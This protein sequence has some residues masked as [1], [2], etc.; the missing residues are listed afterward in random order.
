MRLR[1]TL[2]GF[3]LCSLGIF[4][5][6][7][8]GI[9]TLGYVGVNGLIEQIA[10]IQFH[11]ILV[12][13]L[14]EFLG[15][16][17]ILVDLLILKKNVRDV[18]Y[19][20]PTKH[21]Q[22]T[23]VLTAYNDE[24]SIYDI[25]VEFLDHPKVKRV[26]VVSNN[27]SD[28]TLERARKAGAIAVNEPRQGYGSCVYR[29][30]SEGVKYDDTNYTLLCEGDNT[31]RAYD[32]DKFL[33]YIPHADIVNGSRIVEQLRGKDTQL[34]NFM[35]FGNFFV[36]KLLEMKNI[37]NGTLT[38]VG[39]TYKLCKNDVLKKLL[40]KLTLDINLEYNPYF[41]D[42][43]MKY[44]LRVVECPVTFHPRVGESKGGNIND[45]VALKLGLRMIIGIIISWKI[46]ERK[47]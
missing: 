9:F 47:G 14:L 28:S 16:L 2:T 4:L 20:P 37:K 34:T 45:I 18:T 13:L 36:G 11:L 17:L 25:V 46:W 7:A 30:L 3:L 33:A 38:D 39:T 22:L 44:N 10:G 8:G 5:F 6:L 21:D 40:P 24:L 1:L 12:S 23:V 26:V 35:Y 42:T 41:L 19:E 31:F 29:A 43:A 32:I 27:S 15:G